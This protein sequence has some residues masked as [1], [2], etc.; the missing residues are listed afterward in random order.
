LFSIGKTNNENKR[1]GEEKHEVGG[2]DNIDELLLVPRIAQQV[3]ST[4]KI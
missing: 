4:Q 1:G 3:F 2:N